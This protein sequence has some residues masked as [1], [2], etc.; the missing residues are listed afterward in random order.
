MK[1]MILAAGKGERMLPLTLSTPKPLLP[2]GG[3]PLIVH[4]MHRLA[5]AG[6]T[7]IIINTA[8]IGQRIHAE[9]GD[10]A[11]LGVRIRYSHEGSLGLETAGGL[12]RALP[13]L[14]PAPFLL[15]NADVWTD[16]AFGQ[17]PTT[18]HGLAHLVLVPNPLHNP[19]GDFALVDGRVTN[20][21]SAMLTYSGIAVIHPQ[22]LSG[23]PCG[24]AKLAPLLRNAAEEGLV[25]GEM[26]SGAWDDIGTPER[27]RQ[28]DRRLGTAD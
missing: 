22:L 16:Y 19:N 5:R 10:G 2:A 12:R 26:Y 8:H 6:V 24:P 15:V 25:S 20:K 4:H 1:A 17:L 23:L 14:G 28:L 13:L 3:M 18:L 11:A 27:L 21:G 7:E 9:L